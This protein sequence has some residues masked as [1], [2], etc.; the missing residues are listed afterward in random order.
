MSK[1]LDPDISCQLGLGCVLSQKFRHCH[2]LHFRQELIEW[3]LRLYIDDTQGDCPPNHWPYRIDYL[4][5]NKRVLW[6]IRWQFRKWLPLVK[7]V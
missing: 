5:G 2:G 6:D 3:T 1:S 7:L 4:L